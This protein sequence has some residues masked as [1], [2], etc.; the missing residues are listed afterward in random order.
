MRIIIC[1]LSDI[2][3]K[4]NEYNLLSDKEKNLSK[5]IR[6]SIESVSSRLVNKVFFV[7]TGDIAF[8]G[9]KEEYEIALDFMLKIQ[10]EI[11]EELNDINVDYII[12]PGNH[13][14]NFSINGIRD[15]VLKTIKV[16]KDIDNELIKVCTATQRE[17]D[18]FVKLF[19]TKYIPQRIQN[20]YEY[21]VEGKKI[22]FQAFNSSWMSKKDE[23]QGNIIIPINQLNEINIEDY[24][25]VVSLFHHPLNWIES[26]NKRKFKD[27]IERTS[28]II[29]TGHEHASETSKI[30]TNNEYSNKY[31]SGGVLQDNSNELNSEF[32]VIAID[33]DEQI[34]A[35]I[36]YTWDGDIYV[37]TEQSPKWATFERNKYIKSKQ[38]YVNDEFGKKLND[39]GVKLTKSE[40]DTIYLNDIYIYPNLEIIPDKTTLKYD[41]KQI[42]MVKSID[43]EKFILD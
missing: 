39:T 13:D 24:D 5:A 29:I 18:D 43:S 27:L 17:F 35:S 7:V 1:H 21:E 31:I 9:K 26:N 19:N 38:I 23:I 4:F 12:T 40:K 22:I 25:L 28:D 11:N 36:R 32:N 2:H 33:L 14:C 16:E 41:S 37:P 42:E 6:S 34:E 3:F 30:E 20:I 10:E 8:S 15:R